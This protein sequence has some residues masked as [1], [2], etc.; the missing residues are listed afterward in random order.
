MSYGR[1]LGAVF[2]FGDR[3]QKITPWISKRQAKTTLIYH[4]SAKSKN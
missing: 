1:T 4:P 3:R 2:S